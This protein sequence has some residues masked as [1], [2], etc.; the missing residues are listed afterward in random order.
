MK[1]REPEVKLAAQS[2]GLEV[3]QPTKMR[4]GELTRWVETRQ[5]EVALVMAYGRILPRDVLSAPARGCINLHASLLPHYRGA[6]P[7]QWAIIHGERETGISLMQM[8]EGMDTGPVYGSRLLSIEPDETA[9]HLAERLAELAACM[10]KDELLRVVR[11]ELKAQSQAH[12]R[13][14]YA[15]PLTRE[16]AVI[17]W[18]RPARETHDQV[19]GLAPKP[20]AFTLLRGQVFKIWSTRLLEVGVDDR[21]EPG[22]VTITP[23]QR[24]HIHTSQGT[25]QLLQ[26]QLEGRKSLAASALVNGRVLTQGDRLGQ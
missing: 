7:I 26:A 20:G 1:L 25:L 3:Y 8:D 10:V 23:D 14:T 15:P 9:G 21:G 19:R 11:G 13:A 12:E 17:H 2:L 16:H 18:A 6:A 22:Q 4:T 5:V 24:I